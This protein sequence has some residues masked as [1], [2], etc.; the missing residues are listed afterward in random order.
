MQGTGRISQ[1]STVRSADRKAV[2]DSPALCVCEDLLVLPCTNYCTRCAVG[3]KTLYVL[4][5]PKLFSFVR[6]RL[7]DRASA[8]L[9]QAQVRTRKHQRKHGIMCLLHMKNL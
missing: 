4:Q 8:Q 1:L 3:R 5:Y 7:F 9:G 6:A 2:F